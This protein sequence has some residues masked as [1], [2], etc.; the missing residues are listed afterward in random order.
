MALFVGAA[1]CAAFAE[2]KWH[3]TSSCRS[4]SEGLRS[5]VSPRRLGRFTCETTYTL[6]GPAFG[7][8]PIEI[9]MISKCKAT[10]RCAICLQVSR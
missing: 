6:L 4:I 3:A 5:V 8:F 9:M 2:V 1:L 7:S 10:V